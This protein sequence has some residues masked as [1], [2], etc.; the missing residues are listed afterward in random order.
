MWY[1]HRNRK[2]VIVNVLIVGKDDWEMRKRSNSM[3][4]LT[5]AGIGRGKLVL[6]LWTHLYAL[7]TTQLKEDADLIRDEFYSSI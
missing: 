1:R 7:R 2:W 5:K 6:A 4:M 3:I